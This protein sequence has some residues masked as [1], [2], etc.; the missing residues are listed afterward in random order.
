MSASKVHSLSGSTLSA[1][2]AT[3]AVGIFGSLSA[4]TC[5][6]SFKPTIL[7]PGPAVLARLDHALPHVGARLAERQAVKIVALGSSSTEGVGA[8]SPAKSYPAR[9]SAVLRARYP[10]IDIIVK[11]LGVRGE[12]AEEML[13]RLDRVIAE[14]PDLI[15][16]QVGTNAVLDNLD[17][18]E[19][20][21]LIRAGLARL[22]ATGAD[23]VLIDPQYAPQVINKPNAVGMVELIESVA[24][25]SGIGVFHRFAIMRH[26]KTVQHVSYGTFTSHD[27]LHMNDWSYDRIA[28]LLAGAIG[29]ASVQP[30]R[31]RASS[32]PI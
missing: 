20:A 2:A 27:G 29:E 10:D 5:A 32:G 4:P 12:D 13:A 15:V 18:A 1:A 17:L 14:K 11:N 25:E 30:V 16:W 31:G 21:S 8:S 9:L 28:T 24:H 3:I 6:E 26:W 19:Q 23:V 22:M 7:E